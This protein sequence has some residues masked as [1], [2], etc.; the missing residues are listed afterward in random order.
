MFSLCISPDV[1]VP[2]KWLVLALVSISIIS[3]G[4]VSAENIKDPMQPPAFALNKFKQA[5]IKKSG[6]VVVK[7]AVTQ[8]PVKKSLRL[9]SVLIG[10][11]R[12]VAII[13]DQMLVVGEKIER[14]ELVRIYKDRVQL[15]RNGK[16]IVLR[17][18]DDNTAIRKHAV[19][20]KL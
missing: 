17:L 1:S 15:S 4:S 6:K 9:S 14:A 19:E 11:S 13:N 10:K 3:V 16:K 5:R 20:S 8:K 12:K 7:P 2:A 18:E